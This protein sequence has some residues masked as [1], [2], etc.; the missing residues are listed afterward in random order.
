LLQ[1]VALV[2]DICQIEI[3]L[4]YVWQADVLG[5]EEGSEPR[6]VRRAHIECD[7]IVELADGDLMQ[8]LASQADI[9]EIAGALNLLR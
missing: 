7:L 2:H 4:P 8:L 1:L 5:V 9:A 3:E 6:V